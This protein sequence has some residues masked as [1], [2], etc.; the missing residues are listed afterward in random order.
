MK[1]KLDKGAYEPIRGHE[2]DA[3]LDLRTPIDVTVPK[4]GSVAIDT[5]TAVEIP[6]NHYGKLE[7]KSGLNV[8]HGVV[9]LGGVIDCG[10]DA[11]I[12]VKLYNLGDED[13]HFK[14]GDKIVQLLIIPCHI[15]PVE[16]VDEIYSGERGSNG[17]GSTG[18]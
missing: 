15:S 13:Y 8:K 5:L 17:F 9:S 12:V 10:Y 4:G 1:I 18:A 7:S 6:P 11:S 16:V 2:E 3:G 14:A